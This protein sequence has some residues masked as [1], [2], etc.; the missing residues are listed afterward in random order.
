MPQYTV[1]FLEYIHQLYD[2]FILQI[3]LPLLS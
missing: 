3:F 1:T 2:E